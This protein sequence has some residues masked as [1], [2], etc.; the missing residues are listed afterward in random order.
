MHLAA[1]VRDLEAVYLGFVEA[2][3]PSAS[4]R[5]ESRLGDEPQGGEPSDAPIAGG[6]RHAVPVR[7]LLRRQLLLVKCDQDPQGVVVEEGLPVL[8]VQEEFFDQ[9]LRSGGLAAVRGRSE[10]HTAHSG[11]PD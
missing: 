10:R 3:R 4:L 1:P 5:H 6:D 9:Q 7:D 8:V 2:C 11:S